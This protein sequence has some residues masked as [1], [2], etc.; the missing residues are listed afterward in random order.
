MIDYK[1]KGVPKTL[2]AGRTTFVIRNGGTMDHMAVLLKM[3][4]GTDTSIDELLALPP[5]Q[6]ERYVD[7]LGS[8]EID[9]VAIDGTTSTMTTKLKKG[10]YSL[11]CF[12]QN[13]D[14]EQPHF[15]KGMKTSF[16]VE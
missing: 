4:P 14:T 2:S 5:D 9:K 8:V 16:T 6:A 7:V 10:T 13:R 15:M 12:A 3:K 1:F 11:V